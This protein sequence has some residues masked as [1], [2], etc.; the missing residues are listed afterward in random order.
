MIIRMH[1]HDDRSVEHDR[2]RPMAKKRSFESDKPI[3]AHARAGAELHLSFSG[4]ECNA[5]AHPLI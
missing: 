2:W 5:Q 1:T 4:P 3:S